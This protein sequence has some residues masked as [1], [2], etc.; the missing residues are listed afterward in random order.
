M[1]KLT[2]KARRHLRRKARQGTLANQRKARS[3]RLVEATL[4]GVNRS[5]AVWGDGRTPPEHLCIDVNRNEVLEFLAETRERLDGAISTSRLPGARRRRRRGMIT[6]YWDFTKIKSITPT[7]ALMVA[8]EYDRASAL[9]G[10][11]FPAI[12]VRNWRPT[13]AQVMEEVGFFDL[14]QIGRRRIARKPTSNRGAV[15]RVLKMRSSQLAEPEKAGELINELEALAAD[16]TQDSEVDFD[17]LYGALFEGITNTRHHAY[18]LDYKFEHTGQWW[19]TGS[20]DK[21]SRTVSAVIYDQGITI[22]A[23]LPRSWMAGALSTWFGA[24]WAA[25]DGLSIAAA[26]KVS[27]SSTGEPNR[28]LGLAEMEAFMETCSSGRLRILSRHGEY[29]A[30]AGEESRNVTHKQA[31]NGTLIQWDVTV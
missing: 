18:P 12:N 29:V 28:G 4:H 13:V 9:V 2:E 10:Y 19:A 23:S 1:K 16:L 7:V 27:R 14:L 17:R 26:M 20:V 11:R 24:D 15:L 8:A 25:Q 5:V 30:D 21:R 31:V 3:A 6:G 22:P